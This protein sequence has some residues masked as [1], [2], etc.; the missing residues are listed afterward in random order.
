M[1]TDYV[2]P[3]GDQKNSGSCVAWAVGYYASSI[4]YNT[5]FGIRSAEGNG[6]T[7]LI[8]GFYITNFICE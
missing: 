3:I 6:Q 7:G 5:S 8:H 1:L 4:I 2:P